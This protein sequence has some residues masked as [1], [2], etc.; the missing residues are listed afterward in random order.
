[1]V[2]IQTNTHST[3]DPKIITKVEELLTR[4]INNENP[5]LGEQPVM[6]QGQKAYPVLFEPIKYIKLSRSTYKVTSF[7]DFTPYIRTFN[8]FENYLNSLTEDL[9]DY[10]KVGALKYLQEKYARRGEILNQ[11]DMFVRIVMAP[12]KNC[13]SNIQKECEKRE[14]L[15]YL[16][17]GLPYCM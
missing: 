12:N 14:K 11:N 6:I 8:S 2:G 7:L 16:L 1:M 15:P 3:I 9:N 10:D 13:S 17:Q 4:E 5:Y